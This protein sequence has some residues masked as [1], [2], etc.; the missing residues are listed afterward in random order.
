[1]SD[2]FDVGFLRPDIGSAACRQATELGAHVAASRRGGA[3]AGPPAPGTAV[4]VVI[5]ITDLSSVTSAL[6]MVEEWFG[7]IDVLVN[8]AGITHSV[9]AHDLHLLT[10]ELIGEVFAS[11]A[12]APIRLVRES[13][14]LLRQGLDPVVVQVS[15]VAARTG[16][17]SNI[18]Y[19]GAKA[20]LDAMTAAW[21]RSLA[22]IRFVDVAPS[23]LSNTFVPDRPQE[24]SSPVVQPGPAVPPSRRRPSRVSRSRA[25]LDRPSDGRTIRRDTGGRR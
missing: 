6:R 19:V 20:A 5:D 10:D 23:A 9:P 2:S 18:A 8:A 17:G 14:P 22:P 24:W 16:Q 25:P 15:S 7:R 4:S 1:V 11:N 12:M 13:L 21:A 3:G